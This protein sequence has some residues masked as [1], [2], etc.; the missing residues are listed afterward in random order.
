MGTDRLEA[1]LDAALAQSFP[2]SDPTAISCQVV[3]AS[4]P[5]R[6]AV[7]RWKRSNRRGFPD[8]RAKRKSP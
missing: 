5:I 1:A 2:A 7:L 8:F 6:T 4:P 3:V